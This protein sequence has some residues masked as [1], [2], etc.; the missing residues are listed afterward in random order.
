[1]ANL[2]Q[3]FLLET[4]NGTANFHCLMVYLF[5]RG[6]VKSNFKKGPTHSCETNVWCWGCSWT[7]V[8]GD[9]CTHFVHEPRVTERSESFDL[10]A[11]SHPDPL[12][13]VKITTLDRPAIATD[14]L[15]W[16]RS[17]PEPGLNFCCAVICLVKCGHIDRGARVDW[18]ISGVNNLGNWSLLLISGLYCK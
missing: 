15:S 9:D 4:M 7:W 6:K 11:L 5:Q 10:C 1:M 16:V 17:I 12:D 14:I 3:L 18:N 8:E 13:L 2:I